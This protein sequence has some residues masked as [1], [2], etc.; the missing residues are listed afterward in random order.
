VKPCNLVDRYQHVGGTFYLH[1]W[2]WRWWQQVPAKCWYLY[3]KL[4]SVTYSLYSLWWE[5][6]ISNSV[7]LVRLNKVQPC[8]YPANVLIYTQV[9]VAGWHYEGTIRVVCQANSCSVCFETMERQ[10]AEC[11]NK[12]GVLRC[13]GMSTYKVPKQDFLSIWYCNQWVK[14]SCLP[15]GGSAPLNFPLTLISNFISFSNTPPTAWAQI[16]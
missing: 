2:P 14:K 1:L 9:P 15:A 8:E 10:H 16:V 3:T 6:Q 12:T 7:Y 13:D 5:P 4:H 11:L